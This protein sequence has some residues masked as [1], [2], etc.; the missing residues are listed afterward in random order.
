[1]RLAKP[2]LQFVFSQWFIL[3]FK[4]ELNQCLHMTSKYVKKIKGAADKNL[5]ITVNVN[6]ASVLSVSFVLGNQHYPSYFS[7][8][9]IIQL[10]R[11]IKQIGYKTGKEMMGVFISVQ[12]D[13]DLYRSKVGLSGPLL[14]Y[15]HKGQGIRATTYYAYIIYCLS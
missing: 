9:G 7:S 4:N 3:T 8:S 10:I 12:S 1:M 5:R 13:M 14:I 2:R 6:I 11:L 15:A